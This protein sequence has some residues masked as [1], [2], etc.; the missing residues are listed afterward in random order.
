VD[1][2]LGRGEHLERH[3]GELGQ[4]LTRR[5]LAEAGQLREVQ[6]PSRASIVASY[7]AAPYGLDSNFH[8]TRSAA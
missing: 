5:R 4:R 7:F 6:R 1:A 3:P 8:G 2:R